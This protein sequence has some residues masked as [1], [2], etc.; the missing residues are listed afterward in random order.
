M[1]D[2]IA[3]RS[4]DSLPSNIANA[5]KL[6]TINPAFPTRF[7]GSFK[8]IAHEYPS[9]IDLVEEV[10]GCCNTSQSVKMIVRGIQHMIQRVRDEKHVYL[11][12]FKAGLDVR[13]KIHGLGKIVYN[14]KSKTVS[15]EGYHADIVK[16]QIGELY[17]QGLLSS[18]EYRTWISLVVSR[19]DFMSHKKLVDAIRKKLVLRWTIREIGRGYKVLQNTIRITLEEAVKQETIV[20]V[21]IYAFVANRFIE[22]TNFFFLKN[23]DA[24]GKVTYL[25]EHHGDFATQL[26]QDIAIFKTPSLKKHMK[27]AKRMWNLAVNESNKEILSILYPLFNSPLAKLSQIVSDCETMMLMVEKLA[28]PPTK[29]MVRCLNDIKLRMGT[30]PPSLLSDASASKV[31]KTISRLHYDVSDKVLTNALGHIH[32]SLNTVVNTEARRFLK[33]NHFLP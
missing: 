20:K 31:Y 5:I 28:N 13:Y 16:E 21:D 1:Q 30:I 8:Y 29:Q 33:A 9:D 25:S 27:V 14:H 32:D 4:I 10:V 15:V 24:N 12:D 17:E 3:S 19:P 6:V 7:V 26:K 11:G 18:D 22:I 2:L 23:K